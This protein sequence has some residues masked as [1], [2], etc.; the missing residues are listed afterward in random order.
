MQLSTRYQQ[1]DDPN[2]RDSGT[3][4]K[5][6]SSDESS[7]AAFPEPD[8]DF[9][10]AE[11]PWTLL[12]ETKVKSLL[13]VASLAA[14]TSPLSTSTY[15][16]SIVAIAQDLGVS[17]AK[18]NLT[19]SSY[20]ILQGL[21]PTVTAAFA[22]SYG[23]R[24]A[25]LVC[26]TIWSIANLGLALQTDFTALLLLRCL[27]S[28]GSS[29]TFALAQAVTADLATRAERGKY[30]AYA[31]AI[32][33]MGPVVGPILGG[34]L[35]QYRGWRSVFWCLAVFGI[36]L[37][38]TIFVFFRETARS[39]VGDGSVPPQRW[40]LSLLQMRN[41][42]Q[43]STFPRPNLD[44]VERRQKRPSPF[45]S[46]MLLLD[47]ENLFI[48]A[49]GGLL[50]AGYASVTSVLASQLQQRY[51]YTAVQVGLCYLPVG[52]GSLL[53]YRTTVLLI[54]WN[55]RR[56]AEK[57]G[58]RITKGRQPDVSGFDLEKARL[59]F[60]FPFVIVSAG[61]LAAYGWQMQ[62]H[63]PL[64]A[65]LITMFI[66]ALLLTAVMVANAALLTDLNRED[67][68]AIGA[69]MNLIRLLLSAGAVAVIGPLNKAVG[70]G[71]T[72]TVT[73]VLWVLSLLLLG[74]VYRDGYSWR[75]DVASDDRGSS[76][77]LAGLV[78]GS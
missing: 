50:Y 43:D 66:V 72:A 1:E 52:F 45:T 53:A 76:T 36:V 15:Y 71:W 41:G 19:I 6:R 26:L 57:Q 22:D 18:A 34:L 59:E 63:M 64:P 23:R 56:E 78:R 61:L 29:G 32:S 8:N 58:L 31:M 44:T 69:A 11:R 65:I 60:A 35:T 73:A 67:A 27:Q 30:M 74:I 7:K 10:S 28:A 13:V 40:N 5:D 54:D 42:G 68:A 37:N 70:I 16:P 2:R 49:T 38:A 24:P 17:V 3:S 48:S 62:Y 55:F 51:H 20:Q 14:I 9:E 46:L 47:K 21:S 33:A 12:S 75:A 4:P 77:E 39:V 25:L